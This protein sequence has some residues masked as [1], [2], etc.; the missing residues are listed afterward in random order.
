M[1]RVLGP[2]A[3]APTEDEL[4]RWSPAP[5]PPDGADPAALVRD[6]QA[7]VRFVQANPERLSVEQ[8]APE[9]AFSLAQIL[10]RAD[11]IF[12][13]EK[14][15]AD[16][17]ERW[18]DRAELQRARARVL[19]SLGRPADARRI[20][21]PAIERWPGDPVLRYLL[22]R[23]WM[24]TEPRSAATDAAALAAL[25]AVLEIAPDYVDSDKVTARDIKAVIQQL[26]RARAGGRR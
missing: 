12:L 7:L 18:P 4:V 1:D 25:E 21:E 5:P 20:L 17:A 11:E 26:K 3:V 23:A 15:L 10:L 8:M 13:A 19:V 16:A 9:Q 14:L 6:P 2:E 24:S 22:A